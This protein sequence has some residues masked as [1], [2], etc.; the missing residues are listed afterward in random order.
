MK[1]KTNRTK[2]TR[3]PLE[4]LWWFEIEKGPAAGVPGRVRRHGYIHK[5]LTSGLTVSSIFDPLFGGELRKEMIAIDKM[6]GWRFFSNID[7]VNHFME[8]GE[9]HW[10]LSDEA[11]RIRE[12]Y[13]RGGVA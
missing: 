6:S 1:C 12:E 13:E 4:K 8:R 10:L 2:S 11:D 3:H 5:V 7:D 9:G